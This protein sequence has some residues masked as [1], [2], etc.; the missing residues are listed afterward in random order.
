M[1]VLCPRPRPDAARGPCFEPLGEKFV[2]GEEVMNTIRRP[3][4]GGRIIMLT[5]LLAVGAAEGIA[6]S[7]PADAQALD[8]TGYASKPA[9]NTVAPI[10][11]PDK[12]RDGVDMYRPADGKGA[13]ISLMQSDG[14][15]YRMYYGY[16]SQQT[17]YLIYHG[18][19]TRITPPAFFNDHSERVSPYQKGLGMR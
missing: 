11:V 5:C 12:V 2:V 6:N 4:P 15:Y 14:S 3:V 8:A 19:Y 1:M 9:N 18:W 17:W 13:Y 16:A 10:V 7:S